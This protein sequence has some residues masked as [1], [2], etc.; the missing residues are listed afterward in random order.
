MLKSNKNRGKRNPKTEITRNTCFYL[1][2]IV[3][4]VKQENGNH[5]LQEGQKEVSKKKRAL[6]RKVEKSA[7][8]KSSSYNGATG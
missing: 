2:L 8:N 3:I 4:S 7:E 1:F 5:P 6:K